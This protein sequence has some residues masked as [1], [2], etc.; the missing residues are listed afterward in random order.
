MPGVGRERGFARNSRFL[1]EMK[2][3]RGLAAG[4]L[5]ASFSEDGSD[6]F[7]VWT[8]MVSE[9]SEETVPFFAFTRNS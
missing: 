7:S 3:P 1:K 5:R 9:A 2:R 4:P 8:V 6:Q